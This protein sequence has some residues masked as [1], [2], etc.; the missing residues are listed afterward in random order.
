MAAHSGS[1]GR[2]VCAVDRISVICRVNRTTVSIVL[3]SVVYR[4]VA[5]R[6][7]LRDWDGIDRRG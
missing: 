2:N 5:Y 6:R 7:Y 4:V 1:Y 3:V